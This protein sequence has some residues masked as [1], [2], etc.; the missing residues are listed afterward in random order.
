M[1]SVVDTLIAARPDITARA[2]NGDTALDLAERYGNQA[3]VPV[4]KS[5]QRPTP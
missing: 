2:A 5:A 3:V 1:T 4:L